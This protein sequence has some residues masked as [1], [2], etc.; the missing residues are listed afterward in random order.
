MFQ[1]IKN[2]KFFPV[3]C[4]GLLML[5][6]WILGSG[7]YAKY[8]KNSD[9]TG[10]IKAK[11]FYFESDFLAEEGIE[12]TLSAENGEITFS[13]ENYIDVLRCTE[14][15]ITYTLLVTGN[16]G[17]E[18]FSLSL[19]GGEDTDPAGNRIVSAIKGGE[20]T[21]HTVTMSNLKPGGIYTVEVEG[22]AGYVKTLSAV[23]EV[24]SENANVYRYVTYTPSEVILTVY[25]ENIKGKV[26]ISFDSEGLIPDNTSPELVNLANY[27]DGKYK[28]FSGYIDPVGILEE[29]QFRTYRFFKD[30]S[31]SGG[32]FTVIVGDVEAVDKTL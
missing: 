12:Y 4:F 26:F 9:G 1:K 16:E 25:T 29:Y 28:A 21:K 15:D 19:Q 2:I 31:F 24:A 6:L 7:V 18:D 22:R 10:T 3:F 30:A 11:A 14:D 8:V 23:F 17:F 5:A 32:E 13:L 20:V 27:E